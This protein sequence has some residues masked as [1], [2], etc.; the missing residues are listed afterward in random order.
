MM[1]RTVGPTR[2]GSRIVRRELPWAVYEDTVVPSRV[3]PAGGKA[4]FYPHE[5]GRTTR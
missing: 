1:Y 2:L 5:S 4:T 3:G